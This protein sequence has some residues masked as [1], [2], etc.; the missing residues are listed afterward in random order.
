M[1]TKRTVLITGATGGL[2]DPVVRLLSA[3]GRWVV[4]AAGTN[5]ERLDRLRSL[6]NLHPV[7]LDVT[8]QDSVDRARAEVLT[9]TDGL[10]AVVHLAGASAFASLVGTDAAEKLEHILSINVMGMARVNQ[11]FFQLLQ[12]RG[13]RIIHCSSEA[14]WMTPQPFAGAYY[15][16]KHAVEAYSDS[17]RRELMF[18][19]MSVVV[20]Q[21]GHFRTNMSNAVR[22]GFEQTRKDNPLYAAVLTRLR[23]WMERELDRSGDLD[24][25]ARLVQKV[26]ETRRPRIR[27]RIGTSR[28]LT[29]LELL[30]DRLV[31]RLYL[32]LG[33]RGHRNL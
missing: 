7:V 26:L 17:L 29:L 16:S 25:F 12:A 31:D 23:P 3:S 20:L 18:L 13:G 32:Y 10:D 30:P 24:A 5:R 19:G 9:H 33:T 2:G 28:W 14:G 11:T 15:L 6:P 22:A 1:E 8:R 4:F 21:P 27:Y